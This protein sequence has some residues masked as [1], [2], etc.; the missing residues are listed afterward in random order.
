MKI[1]CGR[2]EFDLTSEDEIMYNGNC[3]QVITKKYKDGWY[4]TTPTIANE[5]AKKLIKNGQL[6]L[7]CRRNCGINVDIYMIKE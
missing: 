4:D 3:Y 7:K 5:L 1:K 6:V 2:R